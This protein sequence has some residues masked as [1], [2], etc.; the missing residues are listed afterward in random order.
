MTGPDQPYYP[1]SGAQPQGPYPQQPSGAGPQYPSGGYAQQPYGTYPQQPAGA[2]PQYPSGAEPSYPPY[3]PAPPGPPRGPGPIERIGP[4]AWRRPDPRLGVALAG[5]GVALAIIGVI[6]W[7]GDYV[8]EGSFGSGGTSGSDSRRL[9]GAGLAFLVVV[10]GYV[11]AIRR[12]HGPLATA[13]VAG[14]ALGVPVTLTFLT[15]DLHSS[16]L[17]S[18]DAVV[19]VSIVIWLISY[20]YV[21]GAR[22]HAFYLGLATLELWAYLLDKSQSSG[23]TGLAT[24]SIGRLTPLPASSGRPDWATIAAISLIFGLA[25][26]AIG[27][28]LD[29]SGRHGMSVALAVSGFVATGVGI[30]ALAAE[31][32]NA[33][34]TGVLLVLLGLALAGYGARTGR[35]FT[36]WVWAAVV[37]AGVLV[38]VFDQID[39]D[40]VP[41]GGFLLIL[42][43]LVV[44]AAGHVLGNAL[45]EDEFPPVDQVAPP[46]H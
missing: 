11:L 14:S 36:T 41:L 34:G 10:I 32:D 6:V 17:A 12:K 20:V 31:I 27:Y 30:G 42:A 25:Y 2:G 16:S 45:G 18:S 9:L 4:R 15:L 26:Y 8:V 29:R 37:G 39:S 35:R 22:G 5:V 33:T 21:P 43:G 38:I 28:Y 24:G 44:V 40:T 23:V 13:G 3:P 46:G 7:G 19:I 1:P